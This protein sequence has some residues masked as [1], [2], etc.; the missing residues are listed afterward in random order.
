MEFAF[1]RM[2]LGLLTSLLAIAFFVAF[3][4]I[5]SVPSARSADSNLVTNEYGFR[6]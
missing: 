1:M 4:G 2:T 5:D 6:I 3:V